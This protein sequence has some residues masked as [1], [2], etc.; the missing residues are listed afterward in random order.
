MK[1]NWIGIRDARIHFS[2][3]IREVRSG[4]EYIIT[5]RGSPVA[6]IV[7]DQGEPLSVEERIK[8]LENSGLIEGCCGESESPREPIELPDDYLRRCLEEDRGDG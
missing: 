7:P 3:I 1:K 6:R 8:N 5:D 4:T 2:R